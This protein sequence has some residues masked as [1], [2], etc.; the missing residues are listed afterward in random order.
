MGLAAC[1]GPLI[2]AAVTLALSGCA[3]Y[4]EHGGA[5]SG[6]FCVLCAEWEADGGAISETIPACPDVDA[7][8]RC[9]DPM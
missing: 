4:Y 7:D 6:D 8:G 5:F 3:S 2:T 1:M 9:D